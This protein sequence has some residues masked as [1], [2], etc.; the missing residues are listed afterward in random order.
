M[1]TQFHAFVR[2]HI[3]PA[4]S[5]DALQAQMHAA[6]PGL[7]P[8][9][10][11]GAG[12]SSEESTPVNAQ[13]TTAEPA[14]S[15]DNDVSMESTEPPAATATSPAT[16]AATDGSQRSEPVHTDEVDT[17][18]RVDDTKTTLPSSSRDV[19]ENDLHGPEV[20]NGGESVTDANKQ[21]G[22]DSKA[23][24]ELEKPEGP[25]TTEGSEKP[26][27]SPELVVDGDSALAFVDK[28]G[29]E[30]VPP[31]LV[32]R[33]SDT[34]TFHEPNKRAKLDE[35]SPSSPQVKVEVQEEPADFLVE[36]PKE[37]PLIPECPFLMF[38]PPGSEND[39]TRKTAANDLPD[40]LLERL[41]I[42][43]RDSAV[44]QGVRDLCTTQHQ[45]EL[46]M[47]HR[48]QELVVMQ[49]KER[50]ELSKRQAGA[51]EQHG[52]EDTR[53]LIALKMTH[54]E[55]RHEFVNRCLSSQKQFLDICA[56]DRKSALRAQQ[57]SMEN[58]KIPDMAVTSD[59]EQIK[60]QVS[61]FYFVR[62]N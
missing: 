37:L 45:R 54:L 50:T 24:K 47:L 20:S 61:V 38:D 46:D 49:M 5:M 58:M 55:Q 40:E 7:S 8:R 48:W 2:E 33:P 52:F 34:E 10:G 51:E 62:L 4:M 59:A 22:D 43:L 16:D 53:G 9:A 30:S 57:I 28:T 23:P 17:N 1:W 32:K 21:S 44:F 19:G 14:P 6:L 36:I 12:V 18:A 27:K 15:N 3:D 11:A 25:E 41:S 29:G 35:N 26:S 60:H 31:A 42:A 39:P 56:M 13:Q